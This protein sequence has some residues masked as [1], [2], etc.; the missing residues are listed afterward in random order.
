MA[1][2]RLPAVDD[3][4]TQVSSKSEGITVIFI[5]TSEHASRH[6]NS[7]EFDFTLAGISN[8]DNFD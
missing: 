8:E 5:S 4:V 2:L 1:H 3:T 6:C 7:N